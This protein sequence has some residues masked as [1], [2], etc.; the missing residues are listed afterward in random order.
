MVKNKLKQN[1]GARYFL[2]SIIVIYILLLFLN[3]E[4][5]V[6]SIGFFFSILIKIFPVLI[7]VFILMVITNYFITQ[8]FISKHIERDKGIKKWVFAVFGGILSTGPVYMWYPLL[9]DLKEKGLTYGFIS[10]FLYNRAI[11]LSLLPLAIL[12]FGWKFVLVLTLVMIFVSLIQG[13]LINKLMKVK[14]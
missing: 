5:F 10:C 1:K 12:Y 2:V 13:V 4:L 9:S 14:K 7:L 11:K 8:K 6:S 3:T